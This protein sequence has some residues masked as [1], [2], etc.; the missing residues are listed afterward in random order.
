MRQ[1]NVSLPDDLRAQLDRRAAEAGHTLGTEIRLILQAG[2]SWE[3]F[4]KPTQLLMHWIGRLAVL[5]KRQVGADWFVSA[6]AHY[7]LKQAVASLLSRNK[8][9]GDPVLDPATLP[10]DRP[11]ALDDPT[12]MGVALEAI[13]SFDRPLSGREQFEI[14]EK[15]R[16]DW[17]SSPLRGLA[18]DLGFTPPAPRSRKPKGEDK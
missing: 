4:D 2:Y 12:A 17:E 16:V 6:G 13:V 10:P 9:A 14:Q 1:V 11:V 15:H 8:P 5:T 7:V 18:A 3:Q